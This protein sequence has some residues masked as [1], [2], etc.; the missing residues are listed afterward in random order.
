MTSLFPESLSG[1]PP[2]PAP[3]PLRVRVHP[4]V[5]FTSPA[6]SFPLRT[7]PAPKCVA[8][9]LEFRSPSRHQH[10]EST[11]ERASQSHS[12]VR[13]RR[14]SRP[15]RFAP[16]RALRVYFTPLPRPGFTF[17]GLA[18]A[19]WPEHLVDAPYPH[20]VVGTRLSP[21]FLADPSS[22]RLAFRVLIRAAVRSHRPGD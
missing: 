12:T 9:S 3:V 15:R 6:E 4:L 2:L 8:P 11:C 22:C 1:L 14:F 10:E 18:P 13:P 16:L 17:Q 5:I 19:A 20:V 7:C 21:S